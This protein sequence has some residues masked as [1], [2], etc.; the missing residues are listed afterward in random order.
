VR[1]ILE[2][3]DIV[4]RLLEHA[5]P[6]YTAVDAATQ[7]GVSLDRVVKC[8]VARTSDERLIILCIPG[9]QVLKIK[10]ARHYLN[11][12]LHLLE[13]QELVERY[14]LTVGAISPLQF[15]ELGAAFLLD[16]AVLD[17]DVITISGGDPMLG[18]ELR[19]ADL[20]TLVEADVVDLK[21]ERSR[22]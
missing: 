11:S 18:I 3:K 16:P 8:M 14:G 2:R 9:D 15:L 19:S 5:I 4:H 6:V 17:A 22:E 10:K 12:G 20:L 21:S 13:R 7:R 1:A